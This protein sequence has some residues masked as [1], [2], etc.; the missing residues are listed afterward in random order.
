MAA[1]LRWKTVFT[2]QLNTAQ[3]VKGRN[4]LR[5]GIC[6]YRVEIILLQQSCFRVVSTKVCQRA[7][8][9]TK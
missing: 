8:C 2:A 3:K 1:V 4:R 6:T 7:N 5:W 9:T